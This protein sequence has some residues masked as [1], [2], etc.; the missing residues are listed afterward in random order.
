MQRRPLV[1]VIM[2]VYDTRADYL[3]EAIKSILEQ[4]YQYFEFII[5]DDG[6]NKAE[7]L[8]CLSEFENT[9]ERLK[10]IRNEINIG[11]TKSLNVALRHSKG[12]YIARMDADDISLPERLDKQVGYMEKN[13]EVCLLG[14][15]T[16]VFNDE[17]NE[18]DERKVYSRYKNPEVRQIRLLF[19]NAGYAHPTFMLRRAFLDEHNIEY[20][21]DIKRAQDYAITT[22]C[23]IAGGKMQ[24]FDEPLLKYREHGG[25]ISNKSYPEQIEYQAIT[26]VRRM[27]ATFETLT[28]DDCWAIARL[29]HEKQDY[30]V[31]Q[32]ISALKK[33]FA[34]NREKKL[35][36]SGLLERELRYEWY[37][38]V[39][40]LT[41]INHRPWGIFTLFTLQSIPATISIKR[42]RAM[43]QG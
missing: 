6:S 36:D 8:T 21:E 16:F 35:F 32:C 23:L 39:M 15:N 7:T 17:G 27:K 4:T 2:A 14:S 13:S 9:D 22:D 20:R 5:I 29:I 1:S 25:Q 41:R 12:V 19:E 28:D 33:L 43:W 24:L 30:S 11:L 40:R 31:K 26:A 3:S 38:K 10:I 42:E 37:R 18:F 34:E